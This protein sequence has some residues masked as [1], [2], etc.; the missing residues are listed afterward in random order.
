M[1]IPNMTTNDNRMEIRRNWDLLMPREFILPFFPCKGRINHSREQ[2]AAEVSQSQ[3]IVTILFLVIRSL[4]IR[5]APD[6]FL[7]LHGLMLFTV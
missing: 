2:L 3:I 7:K 4:T 5:F 6:R 1:F